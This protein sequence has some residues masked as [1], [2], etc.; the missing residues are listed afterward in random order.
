MIIPWKNVF[1]TGPRP[2]TASPMGLKMLS[3]M[4]LSALPLT[5]LSSKSESTCCTPARNPS[6]CTPE[7]TRARFSE[8]LAPCT[9]SDSIC[10]AAMPPSFVRTSSESFCTDC[11]ALAAPVAACTKAPAAV[12][13]IV[14]AVIAAAS[15]ALCSSAPR[16]PDFSSSAPSSCTFDRSMATCDATPSMAS[17]SAPAAAALPVCASS[18][19]R[20]ERRASELVTAKAASFPAT[21]ARPAARAT[22]TATAM[23]TGPAT[24]ARSTRPLPSPFTSPLPPLAESPSASNALRTVPS[25]EPDSAASPAIDPKAPPVLTSWSD[26]AARLAFFAV[27]WSRRLLNDSIETFVPPCSRRI[28]ACISC[29]A[30]V[31][32][33]M[34]FFSDCRAPAADSA[35]PDV[36]SCS[37]TAKVAELSATA[38]PLRESLADQLQLV[39]PLRHQQRADHPAHHPLVVVRLGSGQLEEA[40]RCGA[41]ISVRL[42]ETGDYFP[43]M[44]SFRAPARCTTASAARM[45][46]A[47]MASKMRASSPLSAGWI[48][49]GRTSC[50][51]ASLVVLPRSTNRL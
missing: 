30:L 25:F 24:S 21:S 28:V 3:T 12:S 40:V 45:S 47:G 6:M 50:S 42:R 38:S 23:P 19:S 46:D 37:S 5:V 2:P 17:P 1:T 16:S 44:S 49:H 31:S 27:I 35:A 32:S 11:P 29:S 51:S 8:S 7:N 14:A 15:S 10:R 39:Q 9:E 13:P 48:T 34:V 41:M 26:A 20:L 43:A 33:A 36:L 4:A 18:S 22:T